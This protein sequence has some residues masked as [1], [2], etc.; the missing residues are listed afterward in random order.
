M[1]GWTLLHLAPG[2]WLLLLAALLDRTLRRWFDPVPLK[3]WIVFAVV[4][5]VLFAPVLLL[6]NTLLPVGGIAKMVPYRHLGLEMVDD[7]PLQRDLT[8]AIAPW[9]AQVRRC[10]RDGEW[11]LWNS[12]SAAGLPLLANPQ[13]M[14][15]HPLVVAALPLPLPAAVGVVAALRVLVALAFTFLLLRRQEISE[16]PALIGALAYALGGFMI[17]WLGWPHANS[18]ATL[19]VALYATVLWAQA[20]RRRDLVLLT[21]ALFSVFAAGHP[22]TALYVLLTAGLFALA[23]L[24]AA[25]ASRRWGI[26]R[27]WAAAAVLAGLLAAPVLLPAASYLPETTRYRALVARNHYLGRQLIVPERWARALETVPERMLPIATPNAYGNNRYGAYWGHQNVN[28]EG[29]GFAGTLTLLATLLALA[30]GAGR[31]FPQ[32]RLMAG[33]GLLCLVVMFRP[34]GFVA[35]TIHLPLLDKSPSFHSRVLMVLSFCFAYLA[36]CTWERWRR[37]DLPRLRVGAVAAALAALVL[38]A[39]LAHPSPEDPGELAALRYSSL[40]AQLIGV[41]FGA[42]LLLRR[43]PRP[44]WALWAVAGLLAAELLAFYRPANPPVPRSHFYPQSPPL[45][46]IQE[47]IASD[48]DGFRMLGLHSALPPEF[49]TVYGLADPRV[50]GPSQAADVHD[51]LDPLRGPRGG[52]LFTEADHPLL[53]LL[54]V[55]YVLAEDRWS[56]GPPLAAVFEDPNGVAWERPWALRRLFLP[57]AAEIASPARPWR[58][59]TAANQDFAA[60]A[61]TLGTSGHENDWQAASPA[62]STLV[63][64]RLSEARIVARVDLAEERFMA[65]SVYQDGGWRLLV[66]GAAHPTTLANGPLVAAWL[67][68]GRHRVDLV[69]RPPG[70]LPGAALAGLAAAVLLAVAAAPPRAAASD[71]ARR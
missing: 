12:Y 28:E 58:E 8:H 46:F 6:D 61:L 39:Y 30:S 22:E 65:S 15:F 33:L 43:G 40:A 42:V 27:G 21:G 57:A 49:A 26:F 55:R 54:G 5:L 70:F 24:R 3:A 38:W 60:R 10:L 44:R 45:S 18:A 11:P 4:L 63:L 47:K 35:L 7:N 69:Y 34:P 13:A 20:G 29:G 51:L 31:R 1:N 37:H 62:A 66:D 2:L 50:P 48:P 59:W 68:A 9:Q 36:A 67:P 32:E 53:D 23:R 41:G 14:P 16:L 56:F 25:E 71:G 52:F 64:E 17:L 19:P